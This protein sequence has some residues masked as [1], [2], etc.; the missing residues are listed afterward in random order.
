MA[1]NIKILEFEGVFLDA[2][3]RAKSKYSGWGGVMY[4]SGADLG[5]A[6]LLF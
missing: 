3:R 2:C 1:Y 6:L 4:P 5:G